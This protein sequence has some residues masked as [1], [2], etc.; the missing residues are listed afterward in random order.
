MY[1]RNMTEDILQ[2]GGVVCMASDTVY[3]LFARALDKD[4]VTKLYDI[5]GRDEQKPFII[6]LSTINQ[7]ENFGITSVP[8]KAKVFIKTYTPGPVTFILET[9][10]KDISY[11]TRGGNTLAFRIP[12]DKHLQ[13]IIEHV[14]PLVAP[15]ANPQGLKTAETIEEA[16][17]YFNDTVDLY[18]DGGRIAGEPSTI[19]DLTQ[20]V[21]VV[22]RQ[23]KIKIEL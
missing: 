23:G 3:G 7:L 19:V 20:D 2:K 14:G 17:D 5:K 9:T 8:V 10:S 1:S 4:A 21:P 15:S 12:D 22:L 16:K 6:L 11:L 18:V 13:S